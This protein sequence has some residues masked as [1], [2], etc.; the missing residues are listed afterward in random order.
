MASANGI[1][2]LLTDF[3]TA[4]S[5]V[6]AL[7][8]A[9]LQAFR[10]ATIVDLAHG[11][12]PYA[13]LQAAHLLDGA[14][15]SFPAGTVHVVVV[16]PGVGS[17]RPAVALAAGD[18]F[19]VGPDNGVFT[20]VPDDIRQQVALTIPAHASATF[21]GRDVFAPAAA[22][23]AAGGDLSAIGTPSSGLLRLPSSA[24]KI[25]EAYRALVLH[26]DRFGN[27]VTNTPPRALPRLRSVNGR[28]VRPVRTYEDGQDGE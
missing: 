3:G 5:Y 8:G 20:F 24:E 9:I 2:T 23:L 7:K 22:H 26:C 16:D 10:Q 11:L 25:G 14:W 1:I 12:Q 4:D 13:I 17:R 27:V 21:H 28:P 6:G 19:F 15:S 18:H